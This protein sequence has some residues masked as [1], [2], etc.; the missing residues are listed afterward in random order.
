MNEFDLG[1]LLPTVWRGFKIEGF[2][3]IT[4][5]VVSL[6]GPWVE[7]EQRER[8]TV[9]LHRYVVPAIDWPGWNWSVP[10][11]WFSGWWSHS[12]GNIENI[13]YVNYQ[14]FSV[15][16]LLWHRQA[17][18]WPLFM[19]L[20][21]N[22]TPQWCKNSKGGSVTFKLTQTEASADFKRTHVLLSVQL[23]ANVTKKEVVLDLTPLG[24]M[25]ESATQ[26]PW[27]VRYQKT[28][29]DVFRDEM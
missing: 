24:R 1:V 14:A 11:F 10:L 22:F 7:T 23:S 5:V 28:Q 15:W 16:G 17:H 4:D 26:W 25:R 6:S 2:V 18:C 13:P 12:S 21:L 9:L 20:W 19:T 3:E 27:T 29:T 8:E